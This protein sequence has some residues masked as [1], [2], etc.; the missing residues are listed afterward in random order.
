[1]SESEPTP[2]MP[3]WAA[4]PADEWGVPLK[5]RQMLGRSDDAAVFLSGVVVFSTGFGLTISIRV[6]QGSDTGL[7][8]QPPVFGM[9]LP[10]Q[11]PSEQA[12]S[13]A[14]EFSDGR[15]AT[16]DDQ[17]PLGFH[18]EALILCNLGGGGQFAW[19]GRY[20][21]WPLPSPGPLT[22]SCSWP[23][24]GI[25]PSVAEIDGSAV[26]EAASHAERLWQ[27]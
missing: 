5:V 26:I 20:W 21:V 17:P 4:P 6:R 14:V 24:A 1:M 2:A 25:R 18:S 7:S 9:A 23:A 12:L 22:F 15:R 13:F 3:E 19:E 27:S 16:S 8:P 11:T 10:G